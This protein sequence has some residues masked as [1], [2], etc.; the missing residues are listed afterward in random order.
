ML[1]I[2]CVVFMILPAT[3]AEMF[4]IV[5]DC[6]L[7]ITEIN[8][9]NETNQVDR[10]LI[11]IIMS[12]NYSAGGSDSTT[13]T[14]SYDTVV[15][16]R[17][18]DLCADGNALSDY[19]TDPTIPFARIVVNALN[20]T[21]KTVVIQFSDDYVPTCD[22]DVFV[23]SQEPSRSIP[24]VHDVLWGAQVNLTAIKHGETLTF[25]VDRNYG[26]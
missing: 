18:A 24:F 6:P 14:I 2:L 5:G 10:K 13:Q 19:R 16:Y 23:L 20:N 22:I 25:D 11:D 1:S 9:Y 15:N 7:A 26:A 8:I 17:M 4:V 12:S 21:I 3:F